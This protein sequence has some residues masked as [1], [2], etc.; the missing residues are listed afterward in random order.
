ME[1][2]H[3]SSPCATILKATKNKNVKVTIYYW[4]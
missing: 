1:A 3:G 4:F 2:V